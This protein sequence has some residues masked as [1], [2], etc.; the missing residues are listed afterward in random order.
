MQFTTVTQR[1]LSIDNYEYWL[2]HPSEFSETIRMMIKRKH[3][4]FPDILQL[5]NECFLAP[6]AKFQSFSDYTFM[7]D[8]RTS[9]AS[10]DQCFNDNFL[11][12]RID[13]E[14]S[15]TIRVHRLTPG[16]HTNN[17][18]IIDWLGGESAFISVSYLWPILNY[19]LGRTNKTCRCYVRIKSTVFVVYMHRYHGANSWKISASPAIGECDTGFGSLESDD[20]EHYIF[21]Y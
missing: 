16:I 17:T 21:S 1:S 12:K 10:I 14:E 3:K 19:C 5:V 15:D 9:V 7:G 8:G 13:L 20:S 6:P 4:F 2:V 18:S 11:Y